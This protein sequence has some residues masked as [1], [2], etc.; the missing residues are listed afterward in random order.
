LDFGLP[1]LDLGEIQMHERIWVRSSDSRS[2]NRKSKIQNLKSAVLVGAMLFALCFS[3]EA[4]QAAK[5][6][7]IGLVIGVGGPDLRIQAFHQRLRELG[8]TEGRDI[9]IEYRPAEAQDRSRSQFAELLQ[10]KID[11][12][13]SGN[14]PAIQAAKEATKTIPIVMVTQADPVAAGFV[15][16]LARP[17]GN[18]T[19]LTT[20]SRELSGKRLEIVKEVVPRL[21]RIG[22][23]RDPDSAGGAMGFK[24][25]EAAARVLK[26]PLHSL[27]VRGPNPDLEGAFHAA[28]KGRVGALIPTRSVL[29]TRY[30]KQ[31]ADLAIKNRMPSM[32]ERREYVEAGCL[33][34]YSAD[35]AEQWKRAAVYVD[36]IL[37]GTKPQ[38][39][40]VEQPTKFEFVINLKTAK[41]IGL[42]IPPNVL[43]RADKVIR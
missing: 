32:C 41:Q 13:V 31:I 25:Y 12:F 40:P 37:K 2:D 29:I 3:V 35:E 15:D 7:R 11:L 27:E 16:S 19:G 28:A 26:I 42:T 33:M 20:L 43:A 1:I 8:Y 6:P 30:A 39:L 9:L 36:K 14:F 10:L 4:Q 24:E 21:L 38:D 17:G 5:V 18:I 34:F 23:L 22:V